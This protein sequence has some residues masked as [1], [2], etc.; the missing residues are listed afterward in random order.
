MTAEMVSAPAVVAPV[1]EDQ[2]PAVDLVVVDAPAIA[3]GP[4]V[5]GAVLEVWAVT[6]GTWSGIKTI[7]RGSWA[8]AGLGCRCVVRAVRWAWDQ[9]SDDPQAAAVVAAY[10]KKR[11]AVLKKMKDAD[12]E[13]REAALE[14][15]GDAPSGGRPLL[16]SLGFVALGGLLAVGAGGMAAAL[17]TPHLGALV[18]WEP[19]IVSVGGVAWIVAAWKVAPPP[20]PAKDKGDGDGQEDE[21]AE[22]EDDR[23]DVQTL[24]LWHVLEALADAERVGRAGVHLDA[25]LSSATAAG[26][27]AVDT[28]LAVLRTWIEGTGLPSVDKLGMRVGGKP[29]TRVGLRVD[30]ATEALGGS[31]LALVQARLGGASPAPAETVGETPAEEA[32]TTPAGTPA[33]AVTGAPAP[34][35]LRLISGGRQ[36]PVAAPSQSPSPAA[37][38]GPAQKP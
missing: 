24:L 5:P 21:D 7:W 28:E 16:E 1:T 36:A 4:A 22:V 2:E 11:A 6:S 37:S 19:V 9:A 35:A 18:P 26:L 34:A 13:E 15:L 32:V 33:E 27:L 3:D 12:E 30:G 29:V 20:P 8:L 23:D 25:V 17:I 31:P 38:R 10:G 14:E